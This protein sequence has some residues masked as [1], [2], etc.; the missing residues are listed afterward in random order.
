MVV[1]AL[2]A[3]SPL[4][5]P[6]RAEAD[7]PFNFRPAQPY[8]EAGDEPL[9]ADVYLPE[10]DGPRPGVLMVHG[11]AWQFGSRR[12]MRPLAA[13]LAARG[14]CVVSIDYRLAPKHKFPAQIEDCRAAVRWMRQN[15][16]S[17]KL[18]ST[19]IAGVGVS[20]GGQLVLLL[21]TN[22]AGAAAPDT[23]A[24]A[25]AS[26]ADHWLNAAVGLAAPCDFRPMP[27]D[28]AGLAYWLGGTR[29]ER[30]EAYAAASPAAFVSPDDPPTLLIHGEKDPLVPVAS[31]RAMHAKLSGVGVATELM[32]MP[33]A[34]H[35][36]PLWRADAQQRTFEFLAK[37]LPV[38]L[39]GGE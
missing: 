35:T 32:V 9:L 29:S 10:S 12:S 24:D 18:D 20:A 38:S 19:R 11:G 27:A 13:Q 37:H 3:A 7:N 22:N 25:D 1:A 28:A 4:P 14:Y 16:A 33:G 36:A 34:A 8:G 21:A 15:A 30:P 26:E 39:P 17:L 5:S 2:F 31:P 6:V 23:N